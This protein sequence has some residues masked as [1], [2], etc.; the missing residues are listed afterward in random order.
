MDCKQC[1]S[2]VC[3]PRGTRHALASTQVNNWR[4]GANCILADEMG[5]GKTAQSVTFINHLMRVEN[6]VGPFLVRHCVACEFG[7]FGW[8]AAQVLRAQ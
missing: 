1:V 5:L 7:D 2:C 8:R 4:Q 3:M 6:D